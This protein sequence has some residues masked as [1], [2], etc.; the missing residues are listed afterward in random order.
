MLDNF[1]RIFSRRGCFSYFVFLGFIIVF[2]MNKC[3]FIILKL[4][5]REKGRSWKILDFKNR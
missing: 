2:E 4:E 3:Y 5:K 1:S